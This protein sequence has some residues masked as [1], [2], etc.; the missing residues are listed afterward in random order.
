M[1]SDKIS[2]IQID[3]NDKSVRMLASV[4]NRLTLNELKQRTVQII[5]ETYLP[6]DYPESVSKEFLPFTIA[7]LIGGTSTAAML[8]LSTQSLFVALGGSSSQ[9]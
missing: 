5:A 7:S 4:K 9:S 1:K 8:F 2:T 3:G 6:K